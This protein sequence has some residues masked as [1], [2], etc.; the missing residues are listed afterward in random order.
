MTY[1]GFDATIT[2]NDHHLESAGLTG[3]HAE[4]VVAVRQAVEAMSGAGWIDVEAQTWPP[5]TPVWVILYPRGPGSAP[6]TPEWRALRD[7]VKREATSAL[8]IAGL[9]RV[10]GP[11][12]SGTPGYTRARYF[13]AGSATN[14]PPVSDPN[15]PGTSA[16]TLTVVRS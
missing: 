12:P 2:L 3:R 5:D 13:D 4:A 16:E 10:E 14:Q 11:K 6:D 8:L 1:P 9:R 15:L 7:Q